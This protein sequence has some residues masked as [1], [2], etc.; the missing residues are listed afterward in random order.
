MIADEKPDLKKVYIKELERSLL[1]LNYPNMIGNA[2][3]A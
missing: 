3:F 1:H 2:F